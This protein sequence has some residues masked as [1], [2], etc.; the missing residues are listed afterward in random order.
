VARP[1]ITV[2]GAGIF[3]LAIAWALARRGAAVRVIDPG[4]VGAGASGGLVGALA[5]YAPGD[6][7]A[8]KAFQFDSL[9][10]A[11]EWWA[12]VAAAGGRATG[13]GRTGRL[14]PLADDRAVAA[15]AAQA[16]AAASLWQGRFHAQ[17][18][19]APAGWAPVSPTGL[20]LRDTLSARIAPRAALAAL[21]AAIRARGGAVTGEGEDGATVVWATG[22]AGLAA[23]GA[24]L[25]RDMGGGQKGQALLLRHDAGAAPQIFAAGLHIVPH[26]DGTVA[27]GSTSERE[28]LSAEATDA[29][30]DAV[31]AR[32]VAVFPALGAAPVVARWAGLRP[33]SASRMPL[34]GPWPGRPGHYVANGG[35]K[36]GF[37]LA[38]RVADVMADLLLEGRNAI[39]AE[40]RP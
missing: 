37:G 11:G 20:V 32:A 13:Y 18:E 17:V 21:V 24:D 19:P 10:M 25:G 29:R 8:L 14:Q 16:E 28:W 34:L 4:G 15:A 3:G 33:R 23:L 36:I 39:P 5:P 9:A 7:N 22:A 40:F 6:W 31:L 12:A 26:A 2:R 35:Y 1:E 27:L 38:P 30:L